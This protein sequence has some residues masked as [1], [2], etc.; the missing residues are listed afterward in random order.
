MKLQRLN[1]PVGITKCIKEQNP[2]TKHNKL[3][4]PTQVIG[5]GFDGCITLPPHTVHL[6]S[7]AITA[8]VEL[9]AK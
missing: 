7:L 8:S 5:R 6:S 3:N 9:N 4:K 1:L 2:Y